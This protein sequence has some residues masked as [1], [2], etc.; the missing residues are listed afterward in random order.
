MTVQIPALGAKIRKALP[1]VTWRRVPEPMLR[2]LVEI[3]KVEGRQRREPD[4][5]ADHHSEG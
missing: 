1:D 4:T 3:E 2:L 5:G